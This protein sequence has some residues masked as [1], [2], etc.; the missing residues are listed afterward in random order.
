M[1]RIVQACLSQIQQMSIAEL[2]APAAA[3]LPAASASVSS[4]ARGDDDGG[5]GDERGAAADKEKEKL[6]VL[7][8]ICQRLVALIKCV[9]TSRVSRCR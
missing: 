1:G 6:T 8:A 9:S 2:E 5:D 7:G 3:A 4:A